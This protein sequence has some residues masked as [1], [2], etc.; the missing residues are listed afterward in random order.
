MGWRDLIS[1]LPGAEPQISAQETELKRLSSEGDEARRQR[2]P[3]RA[4]ELYEQGLEL[5]KNEGYLQG[6]E[7]FL[8]Q[9]GALHTEQGHLDL[10]EQT[11][12]EAIAIA[13]RTGESLHL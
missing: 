9:I 10:A 6:Q 8:G 11:L 7:I 2:Q 3:E 5:A 12:V 13:N 1:K 4:L